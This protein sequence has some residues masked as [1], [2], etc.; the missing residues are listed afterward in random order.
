MPTNWM[1]CIHYIE[2]GWPGSNPK[3]VAFFKDIKKEKLQQA[4]IAALVQPAAQTTPI[5][6]TT[7]R[8]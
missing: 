7:S 1:N 2:G 8:L 4:K 3:D 6:I 5:K